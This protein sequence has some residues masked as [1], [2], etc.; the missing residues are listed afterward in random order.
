VQR[1]CTGRHESIAAI[2]KG[3]ETRQIFFDG[4]IIKFT[5]VDQGVKQWVF[6][7]ITNHLPIRVDCPTNYPGYRCCVIP[8]Q[9]HLSIDQGIRE[10]M[11][12]DRFACCINKVSLKWF[13]LRS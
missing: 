8:A 11:H 9:Q 2:Y 12:Q 1:P 4:P 6:I 13:M 3:N 10:R 7:P 5:L